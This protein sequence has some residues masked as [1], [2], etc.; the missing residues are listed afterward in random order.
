MGCKERF[1]I[2]QDLELKT[3]LDIVFLRTD[4][5]DTMQALWLPSLG[6]H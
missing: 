2:P 3:T 1:E 4:F 6:C 5:C